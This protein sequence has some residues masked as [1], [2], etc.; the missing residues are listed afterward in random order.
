MKYSILFCSLFVISVFLNAQDNDPIVMKINGK[1]VSR[2][3]FEYNFNKNNGENVVEQKT[4]DE[5]VDLFINYKLKVEAAL[6]ARYDTLTSFQKEFASYRNQQILPY[7]VSPQAE[8]KEVRNYYDMMKQ[9]IG[10]EGLVFP[11]HIMTLASQKA[12]QEEWNKAKIR[13]DSIYQALQQ[14]ADFSQLAQQCSEDKG[15]AGR[16]GAL[17]WISKGQ[18]IKEFEEAAFSLQ[19]GQMS[20]VVKSPMGYHIILMQDCKQLESYEELK[21]QIQKFLEQRGMKDRIATVTID[22]LGKASHLTSDQIIEN[23]CKELCATNSELKYLIQEYHDGLLLYEIS[24][25]EVWENAATDEKALEQYFKANK[26]K[27]KWEA[28]RYKGLVCHAKDEEVQ[29]QV[30]KLLKSVNET[31]W[32]DTLRATFNRDSLKQ[33][34]VEKNLFKE[35]DNRYVDYMV[36]KSKKQPKSMKMY[37]VTAVYGKKLKKPATWTDVRGEVISDYQT[38]CENEFVRKLREKYKVEVYEDVLKTVNKH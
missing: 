33:I 25:R 6:D 3:E 26:S 16:G 30:R 14:G 17:G 38:A 21:P 34:R 36:F 29:K 12:G 10:P 9:G 8:E 1:D 2:S 35:G 28:P 32:I 7:F 15:S 20:S 37:P 24:S 4:I 18:T 11:A 19:K 22:S 27:Y 31:R 13:I 23:K 5:Y